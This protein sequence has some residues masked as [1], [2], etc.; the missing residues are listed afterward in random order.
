MKKGFLFNILILF[1]TTTLCIILL[2]FISRIT[3]TR[4]RLLCTQYYTNLDWD[5]KDIKD[6]PYKRNEVCEKKARGTN[7]IFKVQI[8]NQGFRDYEYNLEKPKNS[9]R[10]AC[11]GDSVTFGEGVD[12]EY[13][14]VKQL[15]RKL[16]NYCSK[17]IEVLN[18]G[19]SGA[20]TVNELE[21]IQKK[22]ILY[23]PDIIMLQMD[24][25]DCQVIN[26][27]KNVDPF[28]NKI[29]LKL[30]ESKFELS[31]W[32]KCKLEFYKYYKYRKNMTIQDEYNN[33]LEPLKII[34]DI[35][36][37]NNIQP[38]ILSY[39]PSYTSDYYKNVH[40]YLAK[41][42]VPL[43][44]LATSIFNKLSYEEKYVNG[45]LDNS[46][47]VIDSHPNEYGNKIIAENIFNFLQKIPSFENDCVTLKN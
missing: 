26:Q 18:F 11:V 30:K 24:P 31:Y 39:D 2:L 20:S 19:A 23:R 12:L 44:D 47:L 45:R 36:K 16:N 35:C 27:I 25:N 33:V 21:L 13:T 29:I 38:I 46:G 1:S 40:K 10:I 7:K 5:D 22:I 3:I 9:L 15:E 32:L 6:I 37:E 14:Y 17:R 28:L 34:I 42:N 8:N 4:K 43:L 41:Q